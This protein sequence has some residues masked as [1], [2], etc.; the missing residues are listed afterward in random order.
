MVQSY[1]SECLEGREALLGDYLK[2]G[3]VTCR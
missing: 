2:V 3:L 1:L